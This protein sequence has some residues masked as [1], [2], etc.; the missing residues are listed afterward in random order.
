MKEW[1]EV[2]DHG[3]LAEITNAYLRRAEPA[4]HLDHCVQVVK[5]SGDTLGKW[6]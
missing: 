2:G 1:N 4:H 3:C 5:S 6:N